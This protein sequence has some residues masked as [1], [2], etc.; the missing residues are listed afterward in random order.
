MNRTMK[1]TLQETP[2]Q[3]MGTLAIMGFEAENNLRDVA[4]A[5]GRRD[6]A[7]LSRVTERNAKQARL[8]AEIEEQVVE[9]MS[10]PTVGA[11]ERRKL[12]LVSQIALMFER[13]GGQ[14]IEIAQLCAQVILQQKPSRVTELKDLINHA[15]Y[16]TDRAATGL[17]EEDI[18]M[19]TLAI[20]QKRAA[21][22]LYSRINRDLASFIEAG[23]DTASRADLL[24]RIALKA[25]GI[26]KEAGQ[27]AMDVVAFLEKPEI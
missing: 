9:E 2:S 18:D 22:K 20:E 16:I 3:L 7:R 10:R 23:G 26:I 24:T 25:D 27:L 5:L 17:V 12:V 4:H 1:T 13:M 8:R 14:T 15:V 19:A 6:L 21:M 11:R